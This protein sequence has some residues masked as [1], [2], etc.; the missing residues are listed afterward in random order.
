MIRNTGSSAKVFQIFRSSKPW[1]NENSN[2]FIFSLVVFAAFDL[3]ASNHNVFTVS[4]RVRVVCF[5]PK[6][7]E[8]INCLGNFHIGL[9]Y[10]MS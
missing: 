7:F 4:L 9:H 10:Y 8:I 5:L 3:L 6:C 2:K 1:L